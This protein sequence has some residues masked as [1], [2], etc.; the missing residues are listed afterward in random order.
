[1]N[2][3][4]PAAF[5]CSEQTFSGFAIPHN[6]LDAPSRP[7]EHHNGKFPTDLYRAEAAFYS[8][9]HF[10]D[11][12]DARAE[13]NVPD[14][15]HKK[16]K[17]GFDEWRLRR[18]NLPE[19]ETVPGES[20]PLVQK[21]NER[22]GGKDKFR[23]K[24]GV[25]AS[26]LAPYFQCQDRWIFERA[27]D[28]ENVEIETR[29]MAD[30]ITGQ[31]FHSVLSLFLRDLKKKNEIIAPPAENGLPESYSRVLE[32]K[33]KAV[34]NCFPRLPGNKYLVMSML[35]ARLIRAQRELFHEQLVKFLTAFISF[36]SGY[37]V[38]A[39]EKNY[40]LDKGFYYLTGIIDCVLEEEQGGDPKD[41][42]LVIVDFKT[43]GTPDLSDCNGEGG[44]VDFQLPMY[45]RLAEAALKKE[46]HTALFFSITNVKPMVLFGLIKDAVSGEIFPAKEDLIIYDDNRFKSIMDEFDK[47]AE[48]FAEEVSKGSFETRPASLEPC[49]NCEYNK[50]CRSLYSVRRGKNHGS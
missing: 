33:I 3:R 29:L 49:L 25:S 35:T 37:R 23:G 6:G 28:L 20:H 43:A 44:L 12:E 18:E 8:L 11:E 9:L 5:F 7:A 27:L 17:Q 39:A 24:I 10:H 47:K 42:P 46:V 40:Q 48:Q 13:M 31:V 14:M 1:M 26:S 34:F 41:N 30:N 38:V 45:L 32:N 4:L 36:F 16:Q 21:I 2:S 22:F 50:V 19:G 15:I